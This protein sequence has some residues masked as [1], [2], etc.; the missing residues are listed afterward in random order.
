MKNYPN[1]CKPISIGK[2]TLKN[3]L[4][5]APMDT[6]F[7]SKLAAGHPEEVRPCIGCNQGCIWGYFTSG[8]VG[9]AVNAEVGREGQTISPAETPKRVIVVGGGVAGMEAARL[10]HLR[11]HEVTLYE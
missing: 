3:R 9:C 8:Q 1:L 11:G 2:V 6:G 10:A 5:M 4:F 7:G